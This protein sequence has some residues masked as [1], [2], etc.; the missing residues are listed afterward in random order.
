MMMDIRAF[1]HSEEP[2]FTDGA[3][4]SELMRR[5][6]FVPGGISNLQCPDLVLEIHREY[7]DA[8]AQLILTNTF[9]M[10]PIYAASHAPDYDH[11][12]I[13]RKGVE[14][15]KKAAQGK[16]YVMGNLGPTGELLEPMGP[17]TLAAARAAFRE[18]AEV[19]A[20][21]G[22]DCFTV[23][24]FYSLP[25]IAEA[26]KAVREV[27]DLPIL[28]SLVFGPL[29]KQGKTFMGHSIEESYDALVPLGVDCFGHNCGEIT[30]ED[31]AILM[32]PLV[33]RAKIPLFAIPNAGLPRMEK[34]AAVYDMSPEDFAKGMEAV[35]AAGVRI[36]GGCCG[37]NHRHIA[38]LTERIR[39]IQT[40]R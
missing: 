35:Y 4:G 40:K 11:R 3:M 10:N 28:A 19:L 2:I 36:L 13:N 5:G 25:E 37:T 18:Q 21:A 20:V 16:A 33:K 32:T 26:V 14:L 30:P 7:I 1:L 17:L 9:S 39:K 8:G 24:S 6:G 34:G 29:E 31:L 15:A 12:E 23:Q 22:V 27:S 38:A